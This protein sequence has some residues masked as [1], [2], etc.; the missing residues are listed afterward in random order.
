M[1]FANLPADFDDDEDEG[2]S[3]I[4][5]MLWMIM[6]FLVWTRSDVC[7]SWNVHA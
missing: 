4:V 2:N 1:S 3:E 7:A 5:L 6:I